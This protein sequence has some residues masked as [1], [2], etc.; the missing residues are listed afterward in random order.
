MKE[1]TQFAVVK[2]PLIDHPS[3]SL[4]TSDDGTVSLVDNSANDVRLS[5]SADD[6]SLSNLVRTGNTNLIRPLSISPTGLELSD[7]LSEQLDNLNQF[8]NS[9][10]NS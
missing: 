7:N 2:E 4:S 1:K 8:S 9:L 6:F 10:I 3:L 5:M